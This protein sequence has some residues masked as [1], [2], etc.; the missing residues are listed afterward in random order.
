VEQTGQQLAPREVTERTEEHDD[1]IIGNRGAVCARH[2]REYEARGPFDASN[3]LRVRV[4]V[5]APSRSRRVG[6]VN[7][8][9][10]EPMS[11]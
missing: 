3:G 6:L 10:V 2:A 5:E 4:G 8:A 1:V 7:R 9:R 11:S